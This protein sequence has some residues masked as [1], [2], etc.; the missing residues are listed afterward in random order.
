MQNMA[1]VAPDTPVGTSSPAVGAPQAH[2]ASAVG[3]QESVQEDLQ[4]ALSEGGP[5]PADPVFDLAG[6]QVPRKTPVDL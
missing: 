4:A 2:A 6:F 1:A 5:E 3:M